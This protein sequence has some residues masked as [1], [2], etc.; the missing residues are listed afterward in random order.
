[1]TLNN[2]RIA[3]FYCFALLICVYL[4]SFGVYDKASSQYFFISILNT[5]SLIVVPFYIKK[6]DLKVYF[7]Q[8]FLIFYLAYIIISMLSIISA[9]NTTESFV[10]IFQIITFFISL[11]FITLFV[12]EKLIKIDFLLIIVSFSLMVDMYYSLTAYIPFLINGIDYTYSEN[13]RLVGLYGNRNILATILCFKIP[14]VI[15]LA[16]RKRVT[17]ISILSFTLT[18]MA[19]FNITLFTY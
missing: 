1:M 10:K 2:K 9:I 14:F 18:T 5:V 7:R 17:Y 16:Y 6:I 3:W 4:P 11:S 15:L 8:P 12:Y 19:F 13:N